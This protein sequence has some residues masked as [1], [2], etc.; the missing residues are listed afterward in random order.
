[1]K[2]EITPK[3]NKAQREEGERQRQAWETFFSENERTEEAAKAFSLGSPEAL[4]QAEVRTRHEAELLRYPNV[5][6]V[7]EGIRTKDGVPTGERCLVV[8]VERK[9]PRDQLTGAEIL[10]GEIE[11]VSVDVVETGEIT[12]LPM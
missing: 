8:Y 6:G 9:V 2:K 11:G 1:M 12:P 4:K 10:P 3:W 5:V 7:D